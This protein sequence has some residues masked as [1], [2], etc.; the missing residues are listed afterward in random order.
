MPFYANLTKLTGRVSKSCRRKKVKEALISHIFKVYMFFMVFLANV[1]VQNFES[2][3]YSCAKEFTLGVRK[4]Y[5]GVRKVYHGIWK[6]YHGVRKV[7]TG[8]VW[9]GRSGGA[10]RISSGERD[11]QTDKQT[12]EQPGDYRAFQDLLNQWF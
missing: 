2:D 1:S 12:D 11:E 5:H 10:W 3:N 8:L 9:T 7:W 4:V 6:V